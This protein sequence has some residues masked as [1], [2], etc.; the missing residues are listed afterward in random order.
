[1]REQRGLVLGRDVVGALGDPLGRRRLR[2]DRD[3]G[4]VGEVLP[5]SSAIAGGM[6]A[7]KSSVW[8]VFGSSG[9]MRRSAWMKPRSSI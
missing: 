9:T 3:A 7:E 6:V 1:V 5:A 2:R 4:G 8:R